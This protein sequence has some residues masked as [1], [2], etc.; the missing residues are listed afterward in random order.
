MRWCRYDAGDGPQY[1]LVEDKEIRE[2]T[3]TPFGQWEETNRLRGFDDVRLL[4]PVVPP[5]ALN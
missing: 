2:V 4:V 5:E 3:G 1:G